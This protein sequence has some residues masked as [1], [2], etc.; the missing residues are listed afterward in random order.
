LGFKPASMMQKFEYRSPRYHVDLPVVMNLESRMVP[1][2]CREIS[3]EGMLVELTEPVAP[4]SSGSV[5][6][7]YRGLL[8][9]ISVTVAHSGSGQEGL[10]FV[11]R[12]DQDRMVIERLVAL[13]SGTTGQPGP[14]LVGS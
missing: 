14:V 3:K 11:F 4:D 13:V 1:G 10:K 7:R 8:V 9:E 2:R 5:S 6:I 12:C